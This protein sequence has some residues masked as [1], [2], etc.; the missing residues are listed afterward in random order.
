[1]SQLVDRVIQNHEDIQDL[2][3]KHKFVSTFFKRPYIDSECVN[4]TITVN[5]QKVA[6]RYKEYC[7]KENKVIDHYNALMSNAEELKPRNT[8]LLKLYF[9]KQCKARGIAMH[10]IKDPQEYND[11]VVTFNNQNSTHFKMIRRQPLKTG[12]LPVFQTMVKY[13]TAQLQDYLNK[14]EAASG[15]SVTI[16]PPLRT[17][18]WKLSQYKVEGVKQIHLTSEQIRI[19]VKG[20]DAAGII[21]HHNRGSKSDFY[22]YF[23]PEVLEVKQGLTVK[24]S[25]KEQKNNAQSSKI[26]NAENQFSNTYKT[27]KGGVWDYSLPEH[28]EIIIK[29]KQFTTA[30]ER[31]GQSPKT[32]PEHG[33]NTQIVV[34]PELILA[35]KNVKIIP[36]PEFLATPENQGVV[37]IGEP[38]HITSR[39]LEEL[40]QENHILARDLSVHQYDIYKPLDINILQWESINGTMSNEDLA[41][42]AAQDFS[43]SF[44]QLYI[45]I[46]KHYTM[47]P[48]QWY[49]FIE[50][51]VNKHFKTFTGKTLDKVTVVEKMM[52][53]RKMLARA[54]G[55]FKRRKQYYPPFP[56]HYILHS[57]P[58]SFWYLKGRVEQSET[59]AKKRLKKPL[60]QEFVKKAKIKI[61]SN[62]KSKRFLNEHQKC[63]KAVRKFL[64]TQQDDN[65]L[66]DLIFYVENNL[67]KSFTEMLG[68][69]I[70][71]ERLKMNK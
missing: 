5:Y 63:R 48:W 27:A 3:P 31:N 19:Q 52:L 11:H 21:Q 34:T 35:S 61:K 50:T 62:R 46:D 59:Q 29:E 4:K 39:G 42:M 36:L 53:M 65:D 51:I 57:H 13:Y 38:E 44:A 40:I 71:D 37:K 6:A 58:V 33:Q 26:Q 16:L 17:N 24:K 18:S 7:I 41:I 2:A 67:R 55:S 22:A 60:N 12:S 15:N 69:I 14:K 45:N 43:K 64:K 32:D 20:L 70:Q 1:M 30:I 68:K 66:Q 8:P 49:S 25:D 54:V 23:N 28:S 9:K 10:K 47:Q 56:C